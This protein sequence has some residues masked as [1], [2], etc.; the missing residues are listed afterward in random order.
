[1]L[2]KG[3]FFTDIHFGRKSNSDR[4]NQDCLDYLDWFCEQFKSDPDADYVGFL[5]DWHESRT[6]ID[7]STLNYSYQ[8]AQKLNDLGVPIYFVVGNH[9]MGARHT[10]DIY[11]TVPFHEFENFKVIH[12]KPYHATEIQDGAL[13]V[14]FLIKD[15]YDTLHDYTNIPLWAGHFEFKGFILTGYSVKLEHGPDVEQFSDVGTILSG[16]F[17]RR[18]RGKN[19]IY[20][21][22]A[23]P[24]D[25][26]DAND[27]ERGLAIYD[28]STKNT[29]FVDWKNSPKYITCKLSDV[30]DDNVSLMP[31]SYVDIDVDV[32]V[33]YQQLA[34]IET[35]LIEQH[36]LRSIRL[37]ESSKFVHDE[38]NSAQNIDVNMSTDDMIITMLRETDPT[39]FDLDLLETIYRNS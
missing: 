17:H 32:E 8:G 6:A 18:Q 38:S 20:I 11:S 1:M 36:K 25:F 2:K 34:A 10:R 14:P 22:N 23:F 31:N 28:H 27:F 39:K 16:H 13:F 3:Y 37:D 33:T 35:Q 24:M 29:S 7:I 19:A 12:D 9:D 26:S 15:E 4:H 21:G 5:G 30:I